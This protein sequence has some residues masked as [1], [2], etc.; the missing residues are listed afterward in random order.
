MSAVPALLFALAA[1]SAP[2]SRGEVID[3]S[4]TWCG[5]CQQMAPLV[6]RLEREGLPIR[7][8]DVDAQ[9]DLAHR[10]SINAMPT[11]VLVVDGKEVERHTG[12]MSESQLREW[13]SRIPRE[14]AVAQGNLIETSGKPYVADPSVRLGEAQPIQN[15]LNT[16]AG[17]E[18]AA[19]AMMAA[20]AATQP[21]RNDDWAIPAQTQFAMGATAAPAAA[22]IDPMAASVRLKVTINGNINLGSGTIIESGQGVARIVTCGHIFRDFNQSS[23][24]EVDISPARQPQVLSGELIKYD[25]DSD[26]GLLQVAASETLPTS[27]VARAMQAARPADR[28]VSIGCS[29][30]QPPTREELE[31]TAINPYIGPENL[32]CTGIPVQGRSGG[33]LFKTTGELIGIC[34]AADPKR[35]R[36]VYAGLGAVHNLL[37]QAGLAYLYEPVPPPRQETEFIL[38]RDTAPAAAPATQPAA[39]SLL[40]ALTESQ[41]S[42]Q[43]LAASATVSAPVPTA[44]H[45][46]P[47]RAPIDLG[48]DAEDAEIVCIIRRR[49]Q[50][51]SAS[52]VVI[53][54]QASPKLISY[55]K[56]EIGTATPAGGMNDTALSRGGRLGRESTVPTTIS[57]R[58][59][60]SNRLASLP[61]LPE[62]NRRPNLQPTTLTRPVQ[63]RAYVRS[64]SSGLAS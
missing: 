59:W 27:P 36:G 45:Q 6:A 63:P 58:D 62:I 28:V 22:P 12:G 21:A 14:S 18:G 42:S 2:S 35:E 4:A 9:R 64:P 54:H 3:F 31:V 29:G 24:I 10:F 60:Q 48:P 23:T 11:F 17:Q 51:E 53:V 52:Q 30:G 41:Q 50:P 57:H 33:G 13:M 46:Q 20:P 40:S 26:V 44:M 61:P 1:A 5:P 55:L 25:L 43:F 7:S 47:G 56:G 8:V 32:E 19:P 16:N 38:A 15:A 37:Q 39:N 34:I 49:N